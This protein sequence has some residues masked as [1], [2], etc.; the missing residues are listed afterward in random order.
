MGKGRYKKCAQ[1]VPEA[2][3]HAHALLQSLLVFFQVTP[4]G[5]AGN[6]V[7]G[8]GDGRPVLGSGRGRDQKMEDG[9]GT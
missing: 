9:R 6:S 5:H 4:G 2:I 7:W 3:P 1:K 8:P